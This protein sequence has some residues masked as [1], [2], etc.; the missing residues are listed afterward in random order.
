ME[1]FVMSEEELVIFK[2]R[3]K[4]TLTKRIGKALDRE[5]VPNFVLNMKLYGK[6]LG[7][8]WTRYI[9]LSRTTNP[10]GHS[11]HWYLPVWVT[12]FYFQPPDFAFVVGVRPSRGDGHANAQIALE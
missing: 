1:R 7:E 6:L 11:K 2:S 12:L 8:K 9:Q 3:L 5:D 4:L 10:F